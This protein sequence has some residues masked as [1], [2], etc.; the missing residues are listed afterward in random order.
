MTTSA[1]SSTRGVSAD[2]DLA[3]AIRQSAQ[4]GIRSS[5]MG[6]VLL[7]PSPY[8]NGNQI[9]TFSTS[10]EIVCRTSKWIGKIIF[11]YAKTVSTR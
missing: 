3:I 2:G 9:L 6:S 5:I 4:S 10:N 8:V 7:D 11:D 1:K